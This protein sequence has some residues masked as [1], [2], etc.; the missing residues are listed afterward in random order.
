MLIPWE[1][2]K[3]LN[4]FLNWGLTLKLSDSLSL[5]STL[6]LLLLS[7]RLLAKATPLG[8]ATI[9]PGRTTR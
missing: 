4:S 1:T 8:V 2:A 5:S 3:P 6:L 7:V 9:R